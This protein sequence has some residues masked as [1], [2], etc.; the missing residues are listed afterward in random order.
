MATV[1]TLRRVCGQ[2]VVGGFDGTELPATFA[3]ALAAGE[4]G[5]AVLFARNLTPDP[6]QCADLTRSIA[7][8]APPHMAPLLAVD[9]EGG[10][11]QRLRAPVLQLPPM[12]K[13]GQ[14]ADPRLVSDAAE[15][16]GRQLAA[17]GF[18]MDFAPVLDLDTCADNPIIGDRS[19]GADYRL[20]EELGRAFSEGLGA[21]GILSCAK[22]FPGH[23]DTTKDSHLELPVVTLDW[24]QV[25]NLHARPFLR[26]PQKHDAIM[27]AHV[28]YPALDP[29][30][31]ATLSRPILGLARNWLGFEYEGCIVSD[32]L[33]MKAVADRWPIEESAVRA[34][35]A[36]CDA[37]LVCRSEELQ[38]RAVT[39]LAERASGDSAFEA[40]VRE[41]HA[42][43]VTM[44]RKVVP[45]PVATRAELDEASAAARA[46]EPRIAAALGLGAAR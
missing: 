27:T 21:A 34:I 46:M 26:P 37:L 17:L 24:D 30:L 22:H 6:M 5:G 25:V 29:D 33:E 15:A 12:R 39:A 9:Q 44:R 1:G 40:R 45:R 10:R 18:T 19:F 16:L 31:P 41:A 36:G 8:K 23:G 4:R 35:G 2:L 38:D 13:L 32:D 43:F 14:V 28:M 42:R 11:V 3:R 7:E 20:V